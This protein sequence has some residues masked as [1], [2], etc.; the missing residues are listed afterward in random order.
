MR[1]QQQRRI[2]PRRARYV[3]HF[4]R[5]LPAGVSVGCEIALGACQSEARY[6]TLI[7]DL[8]ALGLSEEEIAAT[9]WMIF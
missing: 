6:Q 5:N 2:A 1:E 8:R 3:W 7:E 4:V 9:W